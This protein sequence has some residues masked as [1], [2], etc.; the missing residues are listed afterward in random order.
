MKKLVR[1]VWNINIESID[2][3]LGHVP[4]AAYTAVTAAGDL[5]FVEGIL[6]LIPDGEDEPFWVLEDDV[7]D[8]SKIIRRVK[9]EILDYDDHVEEL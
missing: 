8:K 4:N 7:E 3:H 6:V 2:G 9:F 1:R 5:G